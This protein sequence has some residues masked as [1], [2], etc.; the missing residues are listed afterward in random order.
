[1]VEKDGGYAKLSDVVVDLRADDHAAP[2]EELR[3]LYGLHQEIF[4]KTPRDEWIPVDAELRRELDERLA[5]IGYDRLFDWAAVENLEERVDG[6][7]AVDPVVLD[8]LRRA[9]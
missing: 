9:S 3:R 8:A 6:E 2:V 7:D 5:R 4:G 1:V